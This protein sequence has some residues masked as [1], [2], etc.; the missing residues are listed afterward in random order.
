MEN[1]RNTADIIKITMEYHRPAMA[2]VIDSIKRKK[3]RVK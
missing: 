2:V 1:P 3:L